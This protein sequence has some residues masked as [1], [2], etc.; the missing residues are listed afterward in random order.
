MSCVPVNG[1]YSEWFHVQRGT[2]QG[3]PMSPYLFFISAEI[4]SIMIRQSN[5]VQSIKI[6]DEEILLKQRLLFF[7]QVV[8][9]AI[10]TFCKADDGTLEHLF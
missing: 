1:Q 6:S 2:R 9:S 3:D 7:T 10:C 5:S 8:D 4:M